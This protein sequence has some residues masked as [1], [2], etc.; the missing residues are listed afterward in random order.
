MFWNLIF[1][2]FNLTNHLTLK[3]SNSRLRL[4]KNMVGRR[5]RGGGRGAARSPS[6]PDPAPDS[7]EDDDLK[8]AMELSMMAA[9]PEADEEEEMDADL[10]AAL[11]ASLE[12]PLIKLESR[13]VEGQ[14]RTSEDDLQEALRIS[15]LEDEEKR[16][17]EEEE[18]KK[19][20]EKNGENKE[21]VKAAKVKSGG[22][23]QP[24]Q[25]FSDDDFDAMCSDSKPSLKQRIS[26][27]DLS[28]ACSSSSGWLGKGTS[29][30]GASVGVT[31]DDDKSKANGVSSS[32]NTESKK[33]AVEKSLVASDD[34]EVESTVDETKNAKSKKTAARKRPK[35]DNGES[36][37]KKVEKQDAADD[38]AFEPESTVKTLPKTGR[39]K[40]GRQKR[41]ETNHELL[42]D[43]V[44][45]TANCITG[46]TGIIVDSSDEDFIETND[47]ASKKKSKKLK[48]RPTQGRGGRGRRM[49]DGTSSDEGE[50]ANSADSTCPEERQDEP[51]AGRS[52][53]GEDNDAEA[54]CGE[55]DDSVYANELTI[56][57]S[58]SED[59]PF[60]VSDN[61]ADDSDYE[62]STT[63]PERAPRRVDEVAA[64]APG[65]PLLDRE[66]VTRRMQGVFQ[67]GLEIHFSG[68]E[69]E[70]CRAIA[71][72][73][74]PHQ[75]VALAWMF[76]HENAET[77]G[78]RGGILADDMGLG[79]TL[80]VIALIFT[81]H[82]DGKPMAKPDIGYTRPPLTVNSGTSRGRK[83]KVGFK[84]PFSLK[85][86]S[87]HQFNGQAG[88]GWKPKGGQHVEGVGAKAKAK[89]STITNV[90]DKFKKVNGNGDDARNGKFS[91]QKDRFIADDSSEDDS[92][93]SMKDFI[94]DQSS[95][96]F[97]DMT[98]SKKSSS[99][100]E[101]KTMVFERMASSS[102]ADSEDETIPR[103]IRFLFDI[104]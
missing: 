98:K 26:K 97:D 104:F 92:E 50:T 24:S 23:P 43:Q 42:Q 51:A 57:V 66:A 62:V 84:Q 73:L 55:I 100:Q 41:T 88:A 4:E 54:S 52:R 63:V 36:S 6:P 79:K 29:R 27:A 13:M 46:A 71:T 85:T 3:K 32:K 81:N 9:E 56:E 8:R 96:E 47:A 18:E 76:R 67:S 89:K 19:E 33:K 12:E 45:E 37:S 60:V 95:D 83:G 74:F 39:K 82:W 28:E 48:K 1:C 75:R 22:S 30:S 34:N 87:H 99:M 7:E 90:F 86:A 14:R 64:G 80:T 20:K 44:E 59:P 69:M 31:E 101:K 77:D 16:K 10:A 65:G 25:A 40:I 58:D 68:E 53:E 78:M 91:F 21:E 35:G 2:V 5:R 17:R 38:E 61:S 94:D 70:A 15:L 49:E 103:P 11:K 102:E 93:G 72:P